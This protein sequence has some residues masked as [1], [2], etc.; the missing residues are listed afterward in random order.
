M[1]LS[2]NDLQD[3]THKVLERISGMVREKQAGRPLS[4]VAAEIGVDK[5]HLF[6]LLRG[7]HV[8][9]IDS[10]IRVAAWLGVSPGTLLDGVPTPAPQS[11]NDLTD[12]EKTYYKEVSGM[13]QDA[14]DGLKKVR[15]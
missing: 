13:I 6:R 14:I 11:A 5:T 15:E 4:I 7:S 1:P 9:R 2:N 8:M 12:T 10:L 3:K